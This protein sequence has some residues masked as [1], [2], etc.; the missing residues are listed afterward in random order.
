MTRTTSRSTSS[1]SCWPLETYS[2]GRRPGFRP[3]PQWARGPRPARTRREPRRPLPGPLPWRCAIRPAP[4]GKARSPGRAARGARPDFGQPAGH[5]G[6]L[7]QGALGGHVDTHEH[8]ALGH[9]LAFHGADPFHGAIGFRRKHHVGVGFGFTRQGQH[10]AQ[11]H[12]LHALHADL[13][14]VGL[15]GRPA[16]GA[17]ACPLS[18]Q[19]ASMTPSPASPAA[20]NSAASLGARPR[21]R[22]PRIPIHEHCRSPS[23][24]GV[25]PGRIASSGRP[26][27]QVPPP[28]TTGRRRPAGP[29]RTRRNK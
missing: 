27:A 24:P 3:R 7:Q 1:M 26:C 2:P 29:K 22:A 20:S 16:S 25:L 19:A 18:E 4:R 23:S 15:V 13:D 21:A 8:L 12:G 28:A 17:G 6:L 11:Q 9:A 14:P 10:V 5:L